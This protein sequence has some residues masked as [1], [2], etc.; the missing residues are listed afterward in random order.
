MTKASFALSSDK[1]G[2]FVKELEIVYEGVSYKLLFDSQ[3]SNVHI[4]ISDQLVELPFVI[5]ILREPKYNLLPRMFVREEKSQQFYG[6][7]RYVL[8]KIEDE[9]AVYC[10]K[11]FKNKYR[12]HAMLDYPGLDK[13]GL[14][15]NMKQKVDIESLKKHISRWSIKTGAFLKIYNLFVVFKLDS[16]VSFCNTELDSFYSVIVLHYAPRRTGFTETKNCK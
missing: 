2:T 8:D 6:F 7:R 9:L 12:L 4:L 5:N 10:D 15:T 3:Q 14:L 11:R 13:Q 16:L 1:D